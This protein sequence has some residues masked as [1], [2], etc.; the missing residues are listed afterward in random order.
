MGFAIYWRILQDHQ[1][2]LRNPSYFFFFLLF[3][4]YSFIYLIP[5]P[6]TLLLETKQQ[7]LLILGGSSVLLA[8]ITKD[9]QIR[10]VTFFS[11]SFSSIFGC[12]LL[13]KPILAYFLIFILIAVFLFP[14]PLELTFLV[15]L[16]GR[17]AAFNDW[18]LALFLQVAF[19]WGLL[20]FKRA[21]FISLY[22]LF[23]L[24]TVPLDP[25]YVAKYIISPSS[26]GLAIFFFNKAK[27]GKDHFFASFLYLINGLYF[28]FLYEN[29]EAAKYF[30]IL[31]IFFFFIF[32]YLSFIRIKRERERPKISKFPSEFNFLIS[33]GKGTFFFIFYGIVGLLLGLDVSEN[34]RWMT[35][36]G[37]SLILQVAFIPIWNFIFS[38]LMN[39]NGKAPGSSDVP[40]ESTS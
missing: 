22:L 9:F 33:K 20:H 14:L 15:L 18:G 29:A 27:S 8:V 31:Y 12:L 6:K 19:L 32:S 38:S 37:T 34:E 40:R 11:C 23:F 39:R 16:L 24:I 5:L 10:T 36:W 28:Y 4:I 17:V 25:M 13:N 21:L 2:R 3:L 35:H 1:R 7:I 26:G 30:I